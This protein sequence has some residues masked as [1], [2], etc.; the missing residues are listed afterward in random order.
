M[1]A[2]RR[3]CVT[4]GERGAGRFAGMK[5]PKRGVRNQRLGPKTANVGAGDLETAVSHWTEEHASFQDA[6]ARG[7]K[8]AD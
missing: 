4:V 7:I 3:Y 2:R 6:T 8:V 5:N 1:A